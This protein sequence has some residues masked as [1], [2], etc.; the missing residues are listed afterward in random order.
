MCL[1]CKSYIPRGAKQNDDESS[2]ALCA[3]VVSR[4][5][6]YLQAD[7]AIAQAAKSLGNNTVFEELSLR[8]SQYSAMFEPKTAFFRAKDINTGAW[9]EPFDQYAWGGDYMESG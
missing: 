9:S 1:S 5:L 6:S 4:T 7:Y 8:S 2:T 3:E